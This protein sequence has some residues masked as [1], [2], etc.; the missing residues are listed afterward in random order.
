M[1][2]HIALRSSCNG[3]EKRLFL[4]EPVDILVKTIEL[5]DTSS[6]FTEQYLKA[7]REPLPEDESTAMLQDQ[8][9]TGWLAW[10]KTM[11]VTRLPG[12]DEDAWTID[13]QCNDA[14]ELLRTVTSGEG[15]WQ[16]VSFG[17]CVSICLQLIRTACRSLGAGRSSQLPVCKQH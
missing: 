6:A 1:L 14:L 4:K 5:D 15:W 17:M 13:E 8:L 10:G 7:F 3:D 2:F 11:E 9:D 12:W 16:S